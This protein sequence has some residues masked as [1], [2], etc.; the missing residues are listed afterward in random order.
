MSGTPTLLP[1]CKQDELIFQLFRVTVD[2]VMFEKLS[3]GAR[4][5]RRRA[6]LMSPSDSVASIRFLVWSL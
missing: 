3:D 6:Q 4:L 5:T 1:Y 2:S